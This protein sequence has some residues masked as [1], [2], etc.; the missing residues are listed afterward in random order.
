MPTTEEAKKLRAAGFDPDL[1]AR[2]PSNANEGYRRTLVSQELRAMRR[3]DAESER[4]KR[5]DEA[6][7]QKLAEAPPRVGPRVFSPTSRI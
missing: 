1:L 4:L 5:I 7:K 6:E 2:E 3:K